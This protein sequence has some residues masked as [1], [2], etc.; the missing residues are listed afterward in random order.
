MRKDIAKVVFERPKGA[1]TWA[2]KTP[3]A[4]AVTLDH[5]GEQ[6]NESSN[7]IRRKRQKHRNMSLSPLEH[8][9]QCRVGRPWDQVWSEVCAA[10][11]VRST[12]GGEIRDHVDGLVATKCW[13][14]GRTVMTESCCGA[15]S[16]VRGLFVHPRSGLLT[17][18]REDR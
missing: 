13:I 18:P 2:K 11:D 17:R 5:A 1:R 7:H 8:F 12:L 4:A 10:A 3:R 14:E 6:V 16:R 15:P 9:L